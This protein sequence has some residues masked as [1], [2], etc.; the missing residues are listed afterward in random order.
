MNSEIKIIRTY[1]GNSEKLKREVP[2]FPVLKNQIVYVW[3]KENEKFLIER[4]FE[5]R[6][7]KTDE[8]NDLNFLIKKLISIDLALQEFDE[9][10]FLDWDCKILRP[11]D[12]NF[13]KI[14]RENPIQCPLYSHYKDPMKAFLDFDTSGNEK[15]IRFYKEMD[16]SLKKYSWEKD[17]MLIIPNFGFF[18]S[19]DKT[20]GKKL[21]QITNEYNLKGVVDEISLFIYVNCTL[22]EYIEKYVPKVVRGVAEENT[23]TEFIISRVQKELNEYIDTK[24]DMDIYLKHL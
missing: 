8:S 11:L 2:P 14:V 17:D 22:E 7:Q 24:I 6:L 12:E 13:Y 15:L 18:Y 19:R 23:Q 20:I 21:V 9:I 4:G 3:G 5:T 10:L 1:F 16:K